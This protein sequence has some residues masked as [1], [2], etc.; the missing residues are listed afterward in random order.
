MKEAMNTTESLYHGLHMASQNI[1]GAANQLDRL[2]PPLAQAMNNVA[3]GLSNLADMVRVERQR[4]VLTATDPALVA[5]KRALGDKLPDLAWKPLQLV[6]DVPIGPVVGHNDNYA[7]T[8]EHLTKGARFMSAIRRRLD[9]EFGKDLDRINARL[10][11]LTKDIPLHGVHENLKLEIIDD[12]F[13]NLTVSDGGFHHTLQLHNTTF[14]SKYSVQSRYTDEVFNVSRRSIGVQWLHDV[15][16][17]HLFRDLEIDIAE[18]EPYDRELVIAELTKC[19]DD[20]KR[21]IT[22]SVIAVGRFK[23][24]NVPEVTVRYN[25]TYVHGNVRYN[26]YVHANC[27]PDDLALLGATSDKGSLAWEL[28]PR[29]LQEHVISRAHEVMAQ[30]II[31]DKPL[32]I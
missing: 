5:L 32:A 29:V 14:L 23:E 20:V 15:L 9:K 18:L 31:D 7:F 22:T 1:Y 10:A 6:K 17:T 21:A 2:S 12:H 27:H 25:A 8:K 19:T 11:V 16:Y 3:H 26:F 30:A 28:L 24:D 13:M 4:S